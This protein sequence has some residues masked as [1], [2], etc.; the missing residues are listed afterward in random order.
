[1]SR[2]LGSDHHLTAALDESPAILVSVGPIGMTAFFQYN[3]GNAAAYVQCFNA[4]TVAAVTVGTTVPDWVF[5]AAA[6]NFSQGSFD[7]PIFFS[8]GLVIACTS[9]ATGAGA[10]NA[11]NVV[12]IGIV[13]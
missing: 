9:T 2:G 1:M 13:R 4:A 7:R 6:T 10:P 12:A 8:A 3:S 5:G 11:A